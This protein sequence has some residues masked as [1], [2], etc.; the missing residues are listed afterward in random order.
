MRWRRR[1]GA[2]AAQVAL[3]WLLRGDGVVAIPEGGHLQSPARQSRGG[4]AHARRGG[5]CRDRPRLRAAAHKVAAGDELIGLLRA[6]ARTTTIR[7]VM[8]TLARLLTGGDGRRRRTVRRGDVQARVARPR[9]DRRCADRPSSR[10]RHRLRRRSLP[11][12]AG[13]VSY[14]TA[15]RRA[16]PAVVSVSASRRRP[17]QPR[18]ATLDALLLRRWRRPWRPAPAPDRARLGVIVSPTGYLLTNHHV[19]EGAD[20]IEVQL[21]DGPQGQGAPGRHRPGLR[22]R[23]AQDRARPAAGHRLQQPRRAAGGRRR[24]RDRQPVRRRTDGDLRHRQRPRAQPARH[25]TF[26]NFIQT[27]AAINPGNSGARWS[28][29]QG[30]LLGINTAIFA[31]GRQHGHRLRDSPVTIA[32][33]V[34]EG[35]VRDGQVKRGWI[36]VEPRDLS[37]ELRAA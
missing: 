28:I 19:I 14:A 8:Q 2:T 23:G 6:P 31:H 1:L 36:G 3:A 27:D 9:P 37:P 12:R 34:M 33:Q 11:R 18:A 26:E 16:A 17:V 21:A 15:A 24:A 5:A 4:G 30:N 25:N 7:S 13:P 29:S 20:D 35:L 10:R 22:R 32:R